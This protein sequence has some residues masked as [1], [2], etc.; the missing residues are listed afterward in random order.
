MEPVEQEQSGADEQGAHYERTQDAP[1]QYTPL[2]ARRNSQLGED[3]HEYKN[4]VDREGLLQQ[5]GRQVGQRGALSVQREHDETEQQCKSDPSAVSYRCCSQSEPALLA[6]FSAE[7]F[8][9][10]GQ[11]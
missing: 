2:L 10:E 9:V 8:Q 4:I 3:Q 7:K 6:A 5:I 11:R 1:E